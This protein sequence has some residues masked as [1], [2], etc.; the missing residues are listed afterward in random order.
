MDDAGRDVDEGAFADGLLHAVEDDMSAASEDVVE[1]RGALVVVELC[2]VD[3]H[4]MCPRGGGKFSVLAADEA[5][6]PAASA[7][8]ACGVAFMAD[9]E[10]AGHGEV[11]R[12]EYW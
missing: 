8:F 7:A 9:E 12:E 2:A 11:M 6:T 4:G 3:V 5:V 10:R 1:F